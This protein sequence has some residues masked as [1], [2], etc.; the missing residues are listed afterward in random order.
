MMLIVNTPLT[1][2]NRKTKMFQHLTR[3]AASLPFYAHFKLIVDV[4]SHVFIRRNVVL[5]A[6]MLDP[7]KTPEDE[8]LEHNHDGGFGPSII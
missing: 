1:N 4:V 5:R 8:R 2:P 6:H 7:V 3:L